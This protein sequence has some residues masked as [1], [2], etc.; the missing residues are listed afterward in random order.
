MLTKFWRPQRSFYRL[1]SS[2]HVDPKLTAPKENLPKVSR[3]R[4]GPDL[5][6]FTQVTVDRKIKIHPPPSEYLD[7]ASLRGDGLKVYL[8]IYGCQMNVS[9]SEVVVAILTEVGY[10]VTRDSQEAD[11]WLVVTCSIREGAE[12]KVWRKLHH[13][14]ESRRRRKLKRSLTVGVLGCMAERVRGGL[15]KDGLASIVAGPDSYRDLPRLLASQR[16][17]GGAAVN[18]LLDIQETYSGLLPVRLQ[19][20][21]Q[22]FVSIQRGC[23]NMCSYCI[24]PHTR[25][26]E[27]SRPLSSILAEVETLVTQGVREVTL[28]G[29]NVNSWRDTS[30][31]SLQ[32]FPHTISREQ[33]F[34]TVYKPK[35]GGARFRELLDQVSKVDPGL[36]VRFTSPHPKD[37]PLEVL[38]LVGERE[39][40]CKCLHLPAQSGSSEVLHNMGRGYT[41]DTYL[42]LVERVKTVLPEANITSDF[43]V[44]FCGETEDDFRE[45]ISLVEEVGYSKAFIFPYSMR[46]KT[47]AHR[48][49]RDDVPQQ[50]KDRRHREL[51]EV[52]REGV[53]HL[54]QTYIGST[55]QVLVTGDSKRSSQ[56]LQ[57]LTDN[58]VKVI[59]PKVAEDSPA[60]G[61]LV[62]ISII[63][64]SSE[65][66]KGNIAH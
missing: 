46:E 37:F 47:G 62:D 25:G 52:F 23:D 26:K 44:G 15:L 53:L 65:V 14:A 55:H 10:Q 50:T 1:V 11:I 31:E 64:A 38:E 28:L 51:K 40:L 54:H 57:G 42:N 2:V 4:P 43:I 48:R 33:G 34:D 27:R 35:V 16:L 12:G 21:V 59:F 7:A 9:D 3:L 30:K 20:G 24:V 49:L 32:A 29:Q 22:A 18:V 66:L 5:S 56:D 58:G 6:D 41:R 36:R 13:L 17:S 63:S 19:R 61:D 45:T 39:N 8:D 60:A